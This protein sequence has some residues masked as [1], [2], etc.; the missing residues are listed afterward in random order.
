MH[1]IRHDD[2]TANQPCISLL[3]YIDQCLVYPFICHPFCTILGT[4]CHVDNGWCIELFFDAVRWMMTSDRLN[5]K[6]PLRGW[7]IAGCLQCCVIS[8]AHGNT[9]LLADGSKVL[10]FQARRE[11]RLPN[12]GHRLQMSKGEVIIVNDAH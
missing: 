11:P 4:D 10:H 8:H 3:P 1:V 7:G 12:T 6:I 5:N 9:G 2:I